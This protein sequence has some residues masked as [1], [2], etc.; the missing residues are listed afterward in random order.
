MLNLSDCVVVSNN[1][2]FSDLAG[3]SVILDV[4][5]GVYYGLNEVGARIWNLIQQPK[6]IAEVADAIAQEYEV[7]KSQC[8][9]EIMALLTELSASKLIE[10]KNEASI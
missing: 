2:I 4:R 9:Q 1:Q 10:V 8:E 6:T 3:E 7:E 5:S